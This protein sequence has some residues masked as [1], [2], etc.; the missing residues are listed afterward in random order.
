[1]SPTDNKRPSLCGLLAIAA[2]CAVLVGWA[3]GSVAL[4]SIAPGLVAMN[5]LT[6]VCFVLCGVALCLRGSEAPAPWRCDV[7]TAIAAIVTG[8]GALRLSADVLELTFKVDRLLFADSLGDNRMAPNTALCFLLTGLSLATLDFVPRRGPWPAQILALLVATISLVSLIGYAYG[9]ESMYHIAF[10]AMALNTAAVF[11]LVAI[12]ILLSRRDRGVMA[13]VLHE[14]PGGAM[15]RRLFPTIAA[16]P[17]LGWAGIQGMR[18]GLYDAPFGVALMVATTL[19]LFLIATVGIAS[20]LNAADQER[21]TAEQEVRRFNE[22]LEQR[23]QERT[24]ELGRRD[25][26]LR[27][28]QKMEAVG[29]LAGGIAHEFNN[30]LQAIQGYAQL[31]LEGLAVGDQRRNDLEQVLA[32]SDRAT[33]L[34]R[35]LLGFSRREVLE[36]A[37]VEPNALVTSLVKMIQPLIGEHIKI[38]THLAEQVGLIHVDV[39]HFQQMLMNLCLNA[40]DAMPQGGAISIKTSSVVLNQSYCDAHGDIEPGRYLVLTVA[41]TGTGMPPEVMEHIFEPFFTTKEVG[42]GT[43]LGLSMVYGVVQQHRGSVRVYSEVDMGTT[44]RIYLPTVDQP[45]A[46][47]SQEPKPT[48]LGGSETIL[49]AEDDPFVRKLTVRILNDA[50]Y[51]TITAADGQEAVELFEANANHVSLALL[52]VVMPRLGGRE[53]LQRLKAVRPDIQ[54]VFCSGYDPEMDQVGFVVEDDLRLIHK[55]VN[56]DALLAAIREALDEEPCL[57][58]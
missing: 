35:Q 32:A 24:E 40:R 39:G 41:D 48:V 11:H 20:A 57:V 19:M 4:K 34:T 27:H 25:E 54:A 17:L 56:P 2:G 12:G 58:N 21:R 14:G 55:P 36:L 30:L 47:A 33:T 1:M 43:G 13:V 31:A 5:P 29:T 44:F 37:D 23:V 15:T 38:E 9:A 28:A 50:G 49:V 22:E 46:T 26:Q 42:K 52:D 51:E 8:V 7:A 16:I 6:A 18:I 10:I 3:T 45:L 53:V